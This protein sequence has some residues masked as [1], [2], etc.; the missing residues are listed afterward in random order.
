[1]L[2]PNVVPIAGNKY[3]LVENYLYRWEYH[4]IIYSIEVPA[5]FEYDGASVPRIVWTLTGIL[6]D[7]LQRA[8]ALV[9][10]FIYRYKGDLPVGSYCELSKGYAVP[11][12]KLWKRSEADGLFRKMMKEAGVGK[13]KRYVMYYAVRTFGLK[14]WLD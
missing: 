1:M 7:G 6:P 14:A 2:Q 10:D 3:L 12:G 5:G 9:H 4:G 8:G 13:L 11:V